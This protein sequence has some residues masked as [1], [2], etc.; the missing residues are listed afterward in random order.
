MSDPK[1]QWPK[2]P[3]PTNGDSVDNTWHRAVNA[4]ADAQH[5][6][7]QPFEAHRFMYEAKKAAREVPRL[8]LLFESER[9]DKL[10][11][12]FRKC[13]CCSTGR[14]IVDNHLTCCLGVECRK[15]PHLLSLEK[16]DLPVEQIDWLKAWTCA[17]HILSKGGDVANEGYILT[18]DDRMFWDS[19]SQSLAGGIEP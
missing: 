15:C 4:H 2:V 17:A 1:P 3:M 10:A 18:V 14:H 5:Q 12:S 13:A 11:K 8:A 19:V 7:G 6:A 16:A 9:L